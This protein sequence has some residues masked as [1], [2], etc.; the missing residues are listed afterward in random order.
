MKMSRDEAMD[1]LEVL[2]QGDQLAAR[3]IEAIGVVC[4]DAEVKRLRAKVSLLEHQVVC[5]MYSRAGRTWAGEHC[6]ECKKLNE[7][8]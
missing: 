5:Y 4:A 1:T 2:V 6:T 3:D 8:L 7:A